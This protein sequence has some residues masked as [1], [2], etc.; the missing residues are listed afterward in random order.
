MLIISTNIFIKFV[1]W[2]ETFLILT[3]VLNIII[4]SLPLPLPLPLPLFWMSLLLNSS[5]LLLYV[6]GF[7]SLRVSF[8]LLEV[9]SW[10]DI[11]YISTSSTVPGVKNFLN[12]W[13]R[14]IVGFWCSGGLITKICWLRTWHNPLRIS[15]VHRIY[16]HCYLK[17]CHKYLIHWIYVAILITCRDSQYLLPTSIF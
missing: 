10:S 5:S 16:I 1:T 17:Y 7:S 14:S 11:A 6:S 15:S 12:M 9:G 13:E 3:L 2:S 8:S 4:L